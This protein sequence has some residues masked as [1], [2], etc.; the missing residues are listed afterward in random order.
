MTA[1]LSGGQAFGPYHIAGTAGAGG[2]GVVYRAE[3]RSLARVVALKVIRPDIA[4]S[5]DYRSRFLREAR[6]AAAVDH[7]HVVSVFDVGEQAGRLYLTMQWVDGQDLRTLLDR[8]R[9][10]GPDRTVLI[11]TQ[12]AGALQA[13]HEAGL[14]HRD[15][16]PSNVLM[17]DLG[18]ATTLLPDRLRHRQDAG[19]AGRPDPHRMV[20]GHAGLPVAGAD[21]GPAAGPA[22]RL[23]RAGL[24]AVRGAH[25]P[26]ALGGEND[27]VMQ[28]AH[29]SSPRPVVS[30]A[31]PDLGRRYDGFFDRALAVDPAERFASG[32]AFTDAL[33]AAHAGR[34]GAPSAVAG[35]D[36]RGRATV[37]PTRPPSGASRLWP[38]ALP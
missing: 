29:L 7:P 9:R 25:G 14:V 35:Q 6:L 2:M 37:Q 34:Y 28:W 15:V 32:A 18:G 22:Q 30:I 26:T 4:Q 19:S 16:K 13:V 11:G 1:D 20:G 5:G 38:A 23:V 21:P 24:R 31:C 10:L 27:L 8:Q 36:A 12:L 3:Q 33:Q 17:R